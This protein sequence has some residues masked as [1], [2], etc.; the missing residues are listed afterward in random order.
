MTSKWPLLL[1]PLLAG[2]DVAP[3]TPATPHTAPSGRFQAINTPIFGAMDYAMDTKT[4]LLCKTYDF[5]A[6]QQP[7]KGDTL[8]LIP[9]CVDLYTNEKAQVQKAQNDMLQRSL[10]TPGD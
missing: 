4:G 10:Q 6:F 8:G 2:C 5:N 9:N 7:K 3:T 1:L